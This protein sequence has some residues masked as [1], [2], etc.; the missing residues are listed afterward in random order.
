MSRLHLVAPEQERLGGRTAGAG[1]AAST[2]LRRNA[3]CA[4][5]TS[6]RATAR[7]RV[8]RSTARPSVHTSTTS[9]VVAAFAAT[10]HGP[11]QQSYRQHH[12]DDSMQD[13]QPLEVEEA[14]PAGDHLLLDPVIEAPVLAQQAA[15][16]L[17]DRHVADDIRHFAVDRRGAIGKIM[18]Q[19]PA[20]GRAAK[21]DDDHQPA[22]D[23]EAR[24]HAQAHGCDEG[25]RADR[26]HAW[27]KHVPQQHVL[28][29]EEGIGG[30]GDA[31]RKGA[32]G[33]LTK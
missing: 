23:H 15:E 4:A 1:R 5:S 31:A 29:S 2:A 7:S 25:D 16:C 18:M 22:D 27:R 8:A 12:R 19:R 14:A 13:A 24:G 30:S 33:R 6:T 9:P 20:C 26:R 17:D 21:H 10:G 11:S 28:D 32:G 3:P